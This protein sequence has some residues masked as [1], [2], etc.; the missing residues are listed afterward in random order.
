MNYLQP[1]D[2]PIVHIGDKLPFLTCRWTKPDGKNVLDLTGFSCFWEFNYPD[3]DPH[4]SRIGTV[5]VGTDGT[6][7][8]DL[9]GDEFTQAGKILIRCTIGHP[10]NVQGAIGRGYHLTSSKIMARRVIA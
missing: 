4:I 10:N 2:A 3:V 1:S 7:R 6:T 5:P 9:V 8:Y